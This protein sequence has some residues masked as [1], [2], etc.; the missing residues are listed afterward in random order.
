MPPMPKF[1]KEEIVQTALVLVWQK[2]AARAVAMY[3]FECFAVQQLP[4]MPRFE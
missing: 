3:R 1:T 4:D 2:G